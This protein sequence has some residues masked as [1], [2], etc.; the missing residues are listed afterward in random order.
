[1]K[2]VNYY[3]INKENELGRA[4]CNSQGILRRKYIKL[5]LNKK[6]TKMSMIRNMKLLG[7][8]PSHLKQLEPLIYSF[9][10]SAFQIQ[11]Q[12]YFI[13]CVFFIQT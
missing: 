1:M 8:L 11:E 4:R 5:A 6:G 12:W 2:S 13:V 3:V 9:P 7:M 10:L